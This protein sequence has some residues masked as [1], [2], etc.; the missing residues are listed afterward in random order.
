MHFKTLNV[1]G[2]SNL[3]LTMSIAW[4]LMLWLLA[5]HQ[6]PWY[7]L[8]KICKS[9]SYTRKDF[10]YLWFVRVEEW[11][12]IKIHIPNNQY[13]SRWCH[14][15]ARRQGI[16]RYD[17]D[18]VCTK[19]FITHKWAVFNFYNF[20]K[21]GNETSAGLSDVGYCRLF[22]TGNFLITHTSIIWYHIKITDIV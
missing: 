9:W 2:P 3:G 14:G 12:K 4:L 15:D 10:N 16:S 7:W 1:R 5:G 11:H 6:Q 13:R 8:C 20:I 17:I 22:G 19:Y 18:Q 21:L